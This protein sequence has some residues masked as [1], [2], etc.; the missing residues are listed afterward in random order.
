LRALFFISLSVQKLL[1]SSQSH[2]VGGVHGAQP[3]GSREK[4]NR[5][6]DIWMSLLGIGNGREEVTRKSFA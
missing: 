6:L 2:G 1:P 5:E 4:R 3:C